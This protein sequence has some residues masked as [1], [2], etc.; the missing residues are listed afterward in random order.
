MKDCFI[1]KLTSSGPFKKSLTRL[2]QNMF[3]WVWIYGV[4]PRITTLSAGVVLLKRNMC[5]LYFFIKS[6]PWFK[7]R[8]YGNFQ[9]LGF[10]GSHS[11]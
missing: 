8:G 6:I 10:L 9:F 11:A 3:G 7:K 1:L 5:N 2:Y 4:K